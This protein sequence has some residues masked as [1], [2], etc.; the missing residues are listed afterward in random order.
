ML[1]GYIAILTL[2]GLAIYNYV[3]ALYRN[4]RLAQRTGLPY[5]VA[6][7]S[8]SVPMM[9]LF[10][11]TWIPYIVQHWLPLWLA[12][13]INDPLNNFRWRIKNRQAKRY[14][15]VYLVVTSRTVI[16]CV[17]D[18]AVVSQIVNARHE[19]PKPVWQYGVIQLY[20]PNLVTCE[21]KEW[22]HHRRHTATTFNE[23]NN[24]LVWKESIRQATEMIDY[25]HET[26]PQSPGRISINKVGEDIV[27]FSLNVISGAGFGVQ[28]PF[29]PAA[30]DDTAVKETDIFQDT[31]TPPP[32]FDFTF[33][34]VVAYTDVKIRTV[35]FANLML[36]RWIPRM[37]VPFF[38]RDFAAH[39][40]LENYMKSLIR[41]GSSSLSNN[42][43]SKETAATSNLIHGMLA[44][45]AQSDGTSNG[46]SDRE[47]TSNMHIFTLAGHGT[48]ESALNY[49][50]V[51]LALYSDVQD[52]LHEDILEA[53]ADEPANP[54]DWEY[55]TVFPKL[56]APLCVMLETMRLYPPVVTVPK[57][58][59][60]SPSHIRYRGKDIVLEAGVSINL[61]MNALHYSP[62]YW[63]ADVDT[64]DPTRWDARNSRSFLAQYADTPG[65]VAPGLEYPTVHR[66]V[67]GA[68]IPFSDGFRA[69]LGKKFAQVEFVAALAL[70]FREYRVR[71]ADESPA[72][73]RQAEKALR[74]SVS[75][76]TLGMVEGVPLVFEKR[77]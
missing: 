15:S 26:S 76:V 21:D 68:Y 38:K 75:V 9:I 62:E 41:T 56:I 30:S 1:A 36:P 31:K 14:G 53:T 2:L 10:E 47:I 25:W 37:L 33:R 77:Y 5:V 3:F 63:G 27:Q 20:G 18:A 51:L 61:N 28:I 23:R 19:F 45:R 69:C 29:K 35:V 12:D 72:G 39:R 43:T 22:A 52:W 50:F 11:T 59:G 66:P 71:L 16:C 54:A 7:F 32:G 55:A 24:E 4:I 49:A 8:S 44:S 73:R 48:T 57:W 74:E 13:T 40:D 60:T 17:S 64:F 58:T 65:L 34:S 42:R 67:R 70:L 6:P 46:L